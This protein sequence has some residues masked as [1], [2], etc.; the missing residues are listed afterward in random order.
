MSDVSGNYYVSG[1]FEGTVDFGAGPLTSAGGSDVFVLKLDPSGSVIWSRRFGAEYDDESVTVAIGDGGSIF[2]AG[3]Y[4]A[5][6]AHAPVPGPDFGG[7][8]LAPAERST[9]FVARLDLE[10]NHIRSKGFPG[11]PLAHRE[12]ER[13]ALDGAGNGYVLAGDGMLYLSRLVAGTAIT[14]MTMASPLIASEEEADLAIDNAGNA[15]VVGGDRYYIGVSKCHPDGFPLWSAM[16]WQ[17][18]PE[19]FTGVSASSV[20]VNAAD[21]I[22][23]TGF[24]DGTIDFGGGVLPRGPMLMKL[25]AAGQHLFSRSVRFDDDIALDPAGGI[26]IA[27]GGLV[28]LDASGTETWSIGA[29]AIFEDIALAPNG[30]IA[31]TGRVLAPVDFGTGPIAY[32]A[33]SDIFIATFN[34]FHDGG[35]GGSGSGGEGGSGSGGEGGSGAASSGVGGSG[36][37][38]GGTPGTCVPGTVLTCYTGPTGTVGIGPCTTGTQTCRPDGLGYGPCAGAV[39]PA[40]EI[41]ASPVDEDCDGDPQCPRLPP[42]A[43]AYGG[44]GEQGATSIVSDAWGNYYVSGVFTGTVDFGA[45]PLTSEGEFDIFL[46]KLDPSGSLIWSRRFG[47]GHDEWAPS[48][49]VDGS[50]NIYFAGTYYGNGPYFYESPDFGGGPIPPADYSANALFL[51]KF[52]PEGN[53]IWS[54]GFPRTAIDFGGV[55][56][57][58]VDGIGNVFVLRVAGGWD[59]VSYHVVKVSA[60]G[61]GVLWDKMLPGSES[62]GSSSGSGGIAVDSDGNVLAVNADQDYV[63]SP[64]ADFSVVKLSTTGALLWQRQFRSKAHV[65]PRASA[66]S[67]AVNAAGEVLV[68][69]Y[70]DGTVDFGGGAPGA[71]DK[72][73]AVLVKLDAAGEVI[74]SSTIPYPGDITLDP[75][76]GMLLDGGFVVTKL[77]DSGTTLWSAHV[78]VPTGY[79]GA[80]ADMTISPNGTFAFAGYIYPSIDTDPRPSTA[81][82]ETFVATLNP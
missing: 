72:S 47:S 44:P 50:G 60:G 40:A 54:N 26:V 16:H 59:S 18:A 41:C 20:A 21:E 11:E 71:G 56:E 65:D 63:Y 7:G 33:G 17:S 1:A 77:D 67:V 66:T 74:T 42:W 69:G 35:E 9:L 57:M 3:F 43:R 78:D 2:V 58:A 62:P 24:T 80:G 13:V 48:L 29:D 12:V 8:P 15:I 19:G 45:G 52:D 68:T 81:R 22:F 28:G 76:G 82:L 36:G 46:L 6:P 27:G 30:T 49:A 37:E 61:E 39:A 25:D 53:H 70:T 31:A 73:F 10:G 32:A 4:N 23:V 5:G 38:G 14:W 79:R 55:L 34:H 51:V 75:A 64:G